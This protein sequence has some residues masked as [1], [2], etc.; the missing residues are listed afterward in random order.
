MHPEITD[1]RE[2]LLG[3]LGDNRSQV[4]EQH[5]QTCDRCAEKLDELWQAD[6]FVDLIRDSDTVNERKENS[7]RTTWPSD[8][9]MGQSQPFLS[10]KYQLLDMLGEG[11]M[12]AVFKAKQISI[13][14][15]VAIKVISP[16]LLDNT[17]FVKRFLREMEAVASL[18][19]PK[20]RVC[21]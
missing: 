8:S 5:L 21:I 9:L 18:H 1:I 20:Y 15:T 6:S 12:G 17:E 10:D 11:G 13:D 7:N 2:F 16:K 4:I 3:K 14:R 19:H